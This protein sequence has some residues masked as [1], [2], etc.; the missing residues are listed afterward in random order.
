L[1]AGLHEEKAEE[2]SPLLRE[3]QEENRTEEK[4][5]WGQDARWM[6]GQTLG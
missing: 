1:T 6:M 4:V 5:P 3:K 2:V